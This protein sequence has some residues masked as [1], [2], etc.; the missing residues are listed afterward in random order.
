MT[1]LV[2]SATLSTFD[3]LAKG[4]RL[5]VPSLLARFGIPAQALHDPDM[6]VS[7]QGFI[8]LLEYS[9]SLGHCPDL[10]L[11]L[12][13]ARGI[14]MLGPIAVLLRHAGTVGEALTLASRYLFVH[15][16]ALKLQTRIVSGQPDLV[17][18]V[19]D[20]SHAK[21]TA[22]PQVISLALGIVCQGLHVMTA[23][24]FPPQLVM[25]P[26]APVADEEAY[27]RTY[28]CPVQFMAPVAAVRL[29]VSDLNVEVS[30]NDPH[31]KELALDYLEQQGGKPHT[32]FSDRVRRLVRHFLSAGHARHTDIASALSLHPRTLQRRLAAEGATFEQ[33]V[34]EVRK[35]QFLEL[36]GLPAGPAMT[37]IAH[38]LGY[39]EVSVLT[40]SCKRWFGAT[41]RAMRKQAQS[42]G[43][44]RDVDTPQ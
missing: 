43:H 21:L 39:A 22:R 38:I 3:I 13:Q 1:V 19:F 17:D 8:N 37:Q 26:H 18:V 16:P 32:L 41:P 30:G 27:R 15:S 25:L 2:R 9:A 44:L 12:A 24:R 34:D 36:I 28:N 23:G 11:R 29:R 14:S 4:L 40:R 35:E 31:M 33:L 7:Y 10:G 20:L 42:N 6:L 5:D